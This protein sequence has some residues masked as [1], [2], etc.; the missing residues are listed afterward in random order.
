MLAPIYFFYA[1]QLA[2]VAIAFV[3]IMQDEGM[4]FEWYGDVLDDLDRK[5][6]K[7]KWVTKPLGNCTVCF[8][9]QA[10]LW[11]WLYLNWEKYQGGVTAALMIQHIIFISI[12]IV[13]VKLLKGIIDK[14]S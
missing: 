9:G 8:G 3:G 1:L 7:W 13:C 11:V 14:W 5:N 6:K 10:A 12:T 4:V 2:A